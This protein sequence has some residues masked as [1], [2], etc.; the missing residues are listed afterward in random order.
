MSKLW[1]VVAGHALYR[2]DRAPLG[3]TQVE[4]GGVRAIRP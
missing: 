1:S 3:M 4:G 2:P